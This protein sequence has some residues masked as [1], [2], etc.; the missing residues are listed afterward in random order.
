MKISAEIVKHMLGGKFPE[1]GFC[2]DLVTYFLILAPSTL[3]GYD[4]WGE[5]VGPSIDFSLQIKP[6]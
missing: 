3:Q 1:G 4:D 5:P 2:W 6:D